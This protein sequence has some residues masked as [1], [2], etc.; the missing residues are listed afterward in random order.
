VV[1]DLTASDFLCNFDLGFDRAIRCHSNMDFGITPQGDVLLVNSTAQAVLQK[2]WIWMAIRPGEIPGEPDLGC[3]I[4]KYFYKRV[5]P[6]LLATLE[7][8][9]E[10]QLKTYIP[11]IGVKSVSTSAEKSEYGRLD[12]VRIVIVSKNYGIFDLSTDMRSLEDLNVDNISSCPYADFS[13][14]YN[15]QLQEVVL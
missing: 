10:H 4:Y 12:G 6:N 15:S 1:L 11:E 3:C 14:A 13:N 9:I 8:D 5:T 2:I 7:R